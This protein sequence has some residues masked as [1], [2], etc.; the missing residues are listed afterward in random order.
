M[1][2]CLERVLRFSLVGV[3]LVSCATTERAMHLSKV[4]PEPQ[5]S[6]S[7]ELNHKDK[8]DASK[9]SGLVIEKFKS[10][11]PVSS[12]YDYKKGESTGLNLP[13]NKLMLN[14]DALPLNRFLH[15]ALSDV[16]KLSFVVDP[17]IADR[18]D[19]VT[20]HIASPVSAGRLLAMVDSALSAYQL[21]LIEGSEGIKVVSL[22]EIRNSLPEVFDEHQR[23][24]LKLGRVIEFVPLSYVEPEEVYN[25]SQYFSNG[26]KLKVS[27]NKRLNMMVL[28]GDA[29]SAKK[30]RQAIQA[31]DVPSMGGRHLYLI[32]PAYW[33]AAELAAALKKVLAAQGFPI[34]K[35]NTSKGLYLFAVKEI[36]ALMVSS[37]SSKW[38]SAVQEMVEKLDTSHAVGDKTS[39]FIYF[40]KQA[41]AKYLGKIVNEV[42]GS[43]DPLALTAKQNSKNKAVTAP[44]NVQSVGNSSHRVVVD[45]QRNALI[46]IGN[47]RA[48]RPIYDLLKRLDKPERQVLIEAMV[49]DVTLDGSR[50]LGVEWQFSNVDNSS[51]LTGT[52]ST[53]GGLGVGSGGLSYSLVD[54]ASSVRA[55]INALAANGDAKILSTPRLLAKNHKKASINIGTQISVVKS[56]AADTQGNAVGSTSV[57]R[58]F[59]Y[60]ETGVILSFT[61]VILDDGK[62]ELTIHQEVSEAGSS[63][64]NTPPIFKREI[65]TTLVANSG[66]SI[67]IGGLITHNETEQETK[68]PLLGDIP[69]LGRL[70]SSVSTTDRSTELIIEITPHIISSSHEADSLTKAI[71][72]QMGWTTD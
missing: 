63:A 13:K 42:L 25:F 30:M 8:L 58:T 41:G 15:L 33:Q 70:F 5:K 48:Y 59:E 72:F 32:R 46:F 6:I 17:A 34:A 27:I 68:V 64:N 19:P 16:L 28:V 31:I 26:G 57:L 65:E 69:I 49:A 71:K 18:V 14:A 56:E 54:A 61:P 4:L 24:L 10:L 2:I 47:A 35:S 52:L 11:K 29:V 22:A 60:V 39:V 45:D 40:V 43:G 53:L 66:Q 36:N 67:I 50:Q 3:L 21:G 38:M 1:Y 44:T 37:S 20:L 7:S 51:V 55:K 23:V 12:L 62:V 9:P